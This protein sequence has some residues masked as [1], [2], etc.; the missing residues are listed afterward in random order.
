MVNQGTSPISPPS[1]GQN[2]SPGTLHSGTQALAESTYDAH[3]LGGITGSSAKG[4]GARAASAGGLPSGTRTEADGIYEKAGDAIADVAHGASQ[5]GKD[6]SDLATRYCREGSQAIINAPVGIAALLIGAAIG[7]VIGSM[8]Y[9]KSGRTGYGT[10]QQLQDYEA[11]FRSAESRSESHSRD[12]RD[13][14]L[15]RTNDSAEGLDRS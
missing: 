2:P 3:A 7:Y 1:S 8:V 5:V 4:G 6:A 12:R 9:R 14:L 10:R 11:R 15:W 13:Y